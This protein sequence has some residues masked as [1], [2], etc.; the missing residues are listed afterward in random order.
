MR[1][2]LVMLL[3]LWLVLAKTSAAD[4]G[5]LAYGYDPGRNQ[6]YQHDNNDYNPSDRL[7]GLAGNRRALRETIDNA[8]TASRCG[9]F[10]TGTSAS[11]RPACLQTV[12]GPFPVGRGAYSDAC[13][14][15]WVVL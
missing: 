2:F 5:V 1:R 8:S 14:H 13:Y 15:A 12:F 9:A 4:G 3:L 7:L 11:V 6:T 10:L